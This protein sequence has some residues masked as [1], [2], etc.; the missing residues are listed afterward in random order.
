MYPAQY[1]RI[2]AAAH[3]AKYTEKSTAKLFVLLI[4]F[5]VKG[6]KLPSPHITIQN[7]SCIQSE[8]KEKFLVNQ[9]IIENKYSDKSKKYFIYIYLFNIIF[10]KK[11]NDLQ[12][13]YYKRAAQKYQ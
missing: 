2:T 13:K 11:K 9:S 8:W 6:S 3:E 4:F 1:F 10:N 12:S 7:G 5:S